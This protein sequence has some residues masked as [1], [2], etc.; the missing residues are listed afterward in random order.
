MFLAIDAKYNQ[1]IK[2]NPWIGKP[3]TNEQACPDNVGC[4]RHYEG[5]NHGGA[6]IYWHPQ[7]GTQLWKRKFMLERCSS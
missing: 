1:L 2:P 3:V 6:S 4:Y 7:T 5:L